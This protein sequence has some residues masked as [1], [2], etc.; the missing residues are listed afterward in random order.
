VENEIEYQTPT[1]GANSLGKAGWVLRISILALMSCFI[2]YNAYQISQGHLILLSIYALYALLLS[3]FIFI[4]GW[5]FF[6]HPISRAPESSYN[7][8]DGSEGQEELVSVIIPVYNQVSLIEMVLD[9]AYSSTYKNVEVVVVNDGSTDGTGAVL[10]RLVREQYPRLVVL[11]KQKCRQAKS[12]CMWN[13][14]CGQRKLY[15]TDRL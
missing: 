10:D 3:A 5:L 11:H 4:M 6:K 9:A 7:Q 12:R 8:K 15:C 1:T 13:C 14:Q 2:V